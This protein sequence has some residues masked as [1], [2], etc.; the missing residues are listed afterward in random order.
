MRWLRGTRIAAAFVAAWVA[1]LVSLTSVAH[2]DPI[3]TLPPGYFAE[4]YASGFTNALSGITVDSQ[5]NLYAA[6]GGR[7]IKIDSG[8]NV[9]TAFSDPGFGSQSE[10]VH[11]AQNRVY[12]LQSR[13]TDPLGSL[14]QIS[15]NGQAV[16]LA[17]GFGVTHCLAISSQGTIFEVDRSYLAA[18]SLPAGF[19]GDERVVQVDS[20][21]NEA[22]VGY[23]T[24]GDYGGAIVTL[25]GRLLLASSNSNAQL[26][27][28]NSDGSETVILQNSPL[29]NPRGMA[30]GSDGLL[31]ISDKGALVGNHTGDIRIF[32][33]DL[34]DPLDS[35]KLFAT[36][37]YGG[38]QFGGPTYLAFGGDN[39]LFVSSGGISDPTL[40]GNIVL[41]STDESLPAPIQ[42]SQIPT[43][44]PEPSTFAL[45]GFSLLGLAGIRGYD[46]GKRKGTNE[47]VHQ[48][49]Y[50]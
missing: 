18:F 14:Y 7:V 16:P 24:L 45:F 22:L 34:A 4:V 50:N 1:V 13:E 27:Q 40:L 5:S 43:F 6:D 17:G 35:L 32:T 8:G 41:I 38:A 31:Y 10:L 11:D 39:D 23:P 19:P 29:F 33:L 9:S 2:A 3:F 47:D 26:V 49:R 37:D 15:P 44:V 12:Y 28:L 42:I 30:F 36:I 20:G 46:A 25:D 48:R 21:G